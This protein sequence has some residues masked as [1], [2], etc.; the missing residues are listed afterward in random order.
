MRM[1][2]T[3]K[4]IN[5]K[6]F[7]KNLCGRKVY[8]KTSNKFM[9]VIVADYDFENEEIKKR[10]MIHAEGTLLVLDTTSKVCFSWPVRASSEAYYI[11]RAK[12]IAFAEDKFCWWLDKRDIEGEDYLLDERKTMDNE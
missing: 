8:N 1:I 2:S 10:F 11:L 5:E 7:N 6:I 12:R 4:T 3:K 9:G